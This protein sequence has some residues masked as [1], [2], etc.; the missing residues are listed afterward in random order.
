MKVLVKV[1][2][3]NHKPTLFQ[4]AVGDI[5]TVIFSGQYQN[6]AIVE[7]SSDIIHILSGQIAIEPPKALKTKLQP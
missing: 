6:A 1:N 4:L 5:H 7:D 3:V 2:P